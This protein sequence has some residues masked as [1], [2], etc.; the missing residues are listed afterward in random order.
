M[1]T[2]Q[3]I[4]QN[5]RELHSWFPADLRAG[6]IFLPGVTEVGVGEE[7]CVWVRFPA[8][9]AEIYLTGLVAWR[10]I[11][12]A[13][14]MPAGS[15][16]SLRPAQVDEL[17]FLGRLLTGDVRPLPERHH[18]RTRLLSPWSCTVMVPHLGEWIPA[19][20]NEI[21]PGG[22]RVELNE[23][24]VHEG[25]VIQVNLPWHSESMHTMHLAWYRNSGG[26]LQLGMAREL[27]GKGHEHEWDTLV[28]AASR[29]FSSQIIPH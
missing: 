7:L 22:A 13:P 28:E 8:F 18:P 19:V 14:N 5:P 9:R 10:R 3:K 15:G 17:S 29:Y 12:Q 4:I 27:L 25:C 6:Y 11:R 16:L 2:L 23:L 24:P 21:S 26:Q 20:L 1:Q